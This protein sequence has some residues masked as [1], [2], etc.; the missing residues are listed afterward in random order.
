MIQR[1]LLLCTA[2][3]TVTGCSGPEKQLRIPF[4]A[5]FDGAETGCAGSEADLSLSDLRFFVSSVRAI[6][7]DGVA[8]DLVL[9]PDNQWQQA[10]LALLDFEDGTGACDNGTPDTNTVLR[11]TLPAGEYRGLLF[12]IGVPFEFN[13][14]DPLLAA[15]PLDDTAMHWHWRAGYKFMRAGVRTA[16]DGFW[17]HLGSTGCEGTVKN[18]TGCHFPNR[19]EVLLP[20]FVPGDDSVAVDLAALFRG[21]DLLDTRATDC[22]SGRAERTCE[23]PFRAL[24]LDFATGSVSNNQNVFLRRTGQ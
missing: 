24:G 10:D 16:D 12:T 18:I 8:V 21:T 2:I 20:E 23:A 4:V 14:G 22:S 3:W 6:R 15:P 13:H 5:L 7:N 1:L 17:I 9:Q 11:G 19:A